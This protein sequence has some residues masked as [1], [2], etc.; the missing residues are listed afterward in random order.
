MKATDY[1]KGLRAKSAQQ[2]K[3]ELAALRR[4][5]FSLRMQSGMGQLSKPHLFGDVRRKIAQVKTLMR[6][7]VGSSS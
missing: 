2:L 3:E 1:L 4:E 6:E 7:Q 5:Q